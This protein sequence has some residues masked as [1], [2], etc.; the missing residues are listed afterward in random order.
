[1]AR[2][3]AE[4]AD[5]VREFLTRLDMEG[6]RVEAAYIFG[7]L[8]AGRQDRWSDIDIAVVSPDVSA[9]RF[10]ERIR[11]MTLSSR[12]DSRLEPV[13]FRPAQTGTQGT[14]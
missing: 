12:I 4:I 10:Q 8:A 7:S 11:L 14:R 6:I 3:D 9:D 5:P 13:P 1:M 2:I